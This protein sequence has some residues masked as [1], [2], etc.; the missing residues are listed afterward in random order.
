MRMKYL[1]KQIIHHHHTLSQPSVG[2]DDVGRWMDFAIPGQTKARA[3]HRGDR[4]I[5]PRISMTPEQRLHPT[6]QW[7]GKLERDQTR[8][9]NRTCG[10]WKKHGALSEY[11]REKRE[12]QRRESEG[13]DGDH[14]IRLEHLIIL[15][16][17]CLEN[18]FQ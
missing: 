9:Q 3:T 14:M 5:D 7:R 8:M 13:T 15:F 6:F 2:R 17:A 11:Q 18:S 12:E 1:S 4:S 10:R 16:F